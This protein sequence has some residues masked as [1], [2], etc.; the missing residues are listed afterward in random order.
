MRYSFNIATLYKMCSIKITGVQ[1][2]EIVLKGDMMKLN[3][4]EEVNSGY[5]SDHKIVFIDDSVGRTRSS[6]K[7]I[8]SWR[9]F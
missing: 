5:Y 6:E 3:Y 4:R 7:R 8:E 1:M 9:T 2:A